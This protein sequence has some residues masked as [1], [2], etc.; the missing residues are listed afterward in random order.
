MVT[1]SHRLKQRLHDSNHALQSRLEQNEERL[2][3]EAV[4]LCVSHDALGVVPVPILGIDAS[5]MIAISN[6]AADQVLGRGLSV[7]GEHVDDVLPLD[8]ADS[9]LDASCKGYG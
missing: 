1:E 9:C 4:A 2:Q 6:A 7:V 8:G 3:R 5:G